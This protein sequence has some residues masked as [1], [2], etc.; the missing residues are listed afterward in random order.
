V[1]SD[2]ELAGA[3]PEYLESIGAKPASGKKTL[4]VLN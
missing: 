2:T 1:V 4:R 3:D